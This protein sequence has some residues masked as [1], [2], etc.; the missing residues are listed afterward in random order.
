MSTRLRSWAPWAALAGALLAVALLVDRPGQDGPP[1]DPGSTGPL[2]T[3]G[4]VDTL[5]E[6]GARVD[7][8]DGPPGSSATTALVLADAF[9]GAERS[10]LEA[11]A[12]AG[13]RLVVADESSPL[14]PV[15][16]DAR[17]AFS[18]VEAELRPGCD[19]PALA[20]VGRVRARAASF[21]PVPAGSVGCFGRD[22]KAWLVVTPVGRGAVISVGGPFAFVN[23]QL[24]VDDNA[25]LA[26]SLLA[27]TPA[28][29][30]VFV[31]PAGPGEGSRS[32][33]DLLPR[34]VLVA[35][36]QLMVGFVLFALWRARRLGRPVPE[37]QPLEIG[38][39]ELPLAVGQLLQKSRARD[40]AASVLRDD[41]RR[42]LAARL[43]LPAGSPPEVVAQ[44]AA[45]RA[46]LP[47]DEVRATLAGPGPVGDAELVALAQRVERAREEVGRAH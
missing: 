12:R 10:E 6:L 13:G 14:N 29:R 47:V 33:L 31:R 42:H 45:L 2:G 36:A 39:S 25:V 21:F 34:R 7:V 19:V 32:L 28:D 4:L 41:L 26:V 18:F 16:P 43:G 9:D 38:G 24:G 37:D 40:V 27:P 46:G 15:D 5:R 8:Q 11:W 30:V 22:G 23:E 17:V 1:L 35:L 20:G 3:K 44:V